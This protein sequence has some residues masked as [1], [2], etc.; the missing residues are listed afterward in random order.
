MVDQ[1]KVIS[2]EGKIKDD[3]SLVSCLIHKLDKT[4]QEEL[5]SFLEDYTGTSSLWDKF[6]EFE[7]RKTRRQ[8][9]LRCNACQ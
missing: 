3:F 9:D 7:V 8:S 5:D 1:L 2:A 4:N 6:V